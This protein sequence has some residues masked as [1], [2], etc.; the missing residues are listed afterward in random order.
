[1]FVFF[2]ELGYPIKSA[3][4]GDWFGGYGGPSGTRVLSDTA[5]FINQTSQGE[6]DKAFV[7]A[8]ISLIGSIT[9]LPAGQIN[10]SIKGTYAY[11]DGDTDNP[12]AVLF[13]YQGE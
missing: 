4:S 10:R 5:D 9:G 3:I 6:V 1:M 2:R 12:T 11:I 8:G 7:R 13:G